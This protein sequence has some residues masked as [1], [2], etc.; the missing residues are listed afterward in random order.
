MDDSGILFHKFVE[1]KLSEKGFTIRL[2]NKE[3]MENRLIDFM[4]F[5]NEIRKEFEIKYGWNQENEEYF[6]NPMNNKWKFSYT[7]LNSFNEICFVNFSSVYKDIIHNHATYAAKD[8]RKNDF[9]KLHIIK[10]CQTGIDEGFT[11]QEGYW[12]KNNNGSIILFLKM[13]WKIESIRNDR[14]LFMISNL[15][16][17]RDKTYKLLTES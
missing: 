14:D 2:I 16:E 15:K 8:Y 17:V 4:K 3:L 1:N 9:A 6:L 12:P 10:L 5:V 7:I 11:H 13:G